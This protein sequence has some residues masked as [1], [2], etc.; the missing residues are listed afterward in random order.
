[1]LDARHRW[2]H[3]R[4][5]V[6]SSAHTA[7]GHEG[8]NRR[9]ARS[10]SGM[11]TIQLQDPSS[12]DR[13]SSAGAGLSTIAFLRSGSHKSPAILFEGSEIEAD[14]GRWTLQLESKLNG[15]GPDTLRLR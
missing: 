13:P 2:L 7:L 10:R 5:K 1:M 8:E 12:M 15:A 11:T 4:H 14:R 3:A 9:L 6:L